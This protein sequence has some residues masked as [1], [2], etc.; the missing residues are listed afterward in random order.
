MDFL[1]HLGLGAAVALTASNMLYCFIGCLVGTLIGV[2]PGLG[3]IAT[4]SILL[5]ITFGLDPIGALIMLAGIYYGAQY[6]GSTTA[7]LLRIPGEANSVVTVIDGYA[8][9]EQ[10]RAGIALGIAAIGSFIAGCI[11]TLFIAAVGSPLA[12][13]AIRFSAASYFSLMLMGLV[14]AVTLSHGSVVKSLA[15]TILGLLLSTIGTDIAT[16]GTRRLTF[17]SEYLDSGINFSL[18]AMGL[19]GIGEILKNLGQ[20]EEAESTTAGIGRILPS[21]S[22]IRNSLGAILRGT[23]IGM[24]L[25]ILPGSGAVISPFASYSVEKRIS[26]TPEKFGHGAI[27]GVAGPESA[28]NAAAQTCFIPLLTLGLPASAV[29]ALMIGAMTLQGITPGPNVMNSRPDL[30]WGMIVSMWV[31]NLFLIIINLPLVRVW[32]ALLKVPYR[33]L[34]PAIIV[35]CCMGAY[36]I[37]NSTDDVMMLAVFGLLGFAFSKFSFEP[38][39][40]LL[41]FVLGSMIE[42]NLRRSLIMSQGDMAVFFKEPLSLALLIITAILLIF[43]ISPKL[44]TNRNNI[45]QGD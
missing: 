43:T 33:I 10:G 17:G 13:I 32:V 5:P 41:G 40:L 36:T 34:F 1:Q 11:A 25:G 30:F 39:P 38:A 27:Q 12:T 23:G 26:R 42:D 7:I 2:L 8:M 6:G 14:F 9:A 31:G 15:M 3:P 20:T 4:I 19:F 37:N 44:R 16:A 18:L 28:N 45:F 21:W 29:M 22:D 35:F 24:F